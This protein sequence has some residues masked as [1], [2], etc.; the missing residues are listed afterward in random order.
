M[1]SEGHFDGGRPDKLGLTD[2]T[3]NPQPRHIG[4]DTTKAAGKMPAPDD[5]GLG[6]V[7][8]GPILD[9]GALEV[10]SAVPAPGVGSLGATMGV[11]GVGCVS[12][13]SVGGTDLSSVTRIGKIIMT[14]GGEDSAASASSQSPPLGDA[15]GVDSHFSLH[16]LNG[17]AHLQHVRRSSA[18]TGPQPSSSFFSLWPPGSRP[19]GFAEPGRV[20]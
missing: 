8:A 15:M 1:H 5:E 20:R 4:A 19:L 14:S 6:A 13:A 7:G 18:A 2:P 3:G 17:E 11:A 12:M 9:A 16:F 10:T